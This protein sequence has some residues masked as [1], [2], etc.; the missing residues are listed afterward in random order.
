MDFPWWLSGKES[1]CQ[2]RGHGFDPWSRKIPHALWGSLAHALQ[3]LS[4]PEP[5]GRNHG[6]HWPQLLR[7]AHSRAH[8]PQLMG[9]CAAATKPM[10]LEPAF[11]S[12]SGYCSAKP[13]RHSWKSGP[14]LQQLE[15]AKEP[16]EGL[17]WRSSG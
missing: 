7:P 10:S 6:A 8:E 12:K 14:H 1:A 13:A 11:H 5:A 3:L 16:M 4:P 17:S 15:R 9:P 2:C